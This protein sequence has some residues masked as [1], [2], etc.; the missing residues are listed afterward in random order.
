MDDVKSMMPRAKS[1]DGKCNQS[2]G[3][4]TGLSAYYSEPWGRPLQLSPV[5]PNMGLNCFA[6]VKQR[7]QQTVNS[8]GF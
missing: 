5:S 8:G 1:H 7:Q 3:M 6:G 4:L 2:C